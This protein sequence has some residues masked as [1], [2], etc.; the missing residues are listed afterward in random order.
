MP[1]ISSTFGRY[2]DWQSRND[3]GFGFDFRVGLLIPIGD[4][5]AKIDIGGKWCHTNILSRSIPEGWG[6]GTDLE[7]IAKMTGLYIGYNF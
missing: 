6:T 2:Y 1:A 7:K 3:V 4:G 5:N